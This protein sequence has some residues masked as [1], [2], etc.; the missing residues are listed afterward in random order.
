M[1]IYAIWLFWS[2]R[3]RHFS[4]G[5]YPHKTQIALERDGEK[6]LKSLSIS[7]VFGLGLVL[8]L[9]NGPANAQLGKAGSIE[10]GVEASSAAFVPA[11]TASFPYPATDSQPN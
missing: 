11:A 8:F 3:Y 6:M 9:A 10:G 5:S 4:G 7:V 1:C 2:G